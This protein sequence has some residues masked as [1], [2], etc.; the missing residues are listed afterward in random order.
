MT[1]R[2][3]DSSS[4]N[5]EVKSTKKSNS[6]NQSYIQTANL[7]SKTKLFDR[8]LSLNPNGI[9]PN[10]KV[11]NPSERSESEDVSPKSKKKSKSKNKQKDNTVISDNE[12][13]STI[14]LLLNETKEKV[15][16]NKSK[17]SSKHKN[18]D[19]Q[20]DA[21]SMKVLANIKSEIE[22]EYSVDSN[23]AQYVDTNEECLNGNDGVT[24]INQEQ[25]DENIVSSVEKKIH[26]LQDIRLI[27]VKDLTTQEQLNE[28]YPK[29]RKIDLHTKMKVKDSVD[30]YLL[31]VP[32]S[33]NPENLLNSE[34]NLEESC[35]VNIDGDSYT[36]K[37]TSNVP[38]PTLVLN[39]KTEILHFKKN[40]VLEKYIKAN[41]EPKIPSKEKFIVPLPSHLKNRHPLFGSNYEDRIQLDETIEE[42]LDEALKNLLKPSKSKKH[43]KVE[44]ANNAMGHST[45]LP[46]VSLTNDFSFDLSSISST[47]KTKKIKQ[48]NDDYSFIADLFKTEDQKQKKQKISK[49]K[50]DIAHSEEV[51]DEIKVFKRK[52]EPL[53]SSPK[54]KKKKK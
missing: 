15:L 14:A 46:D 54:K 35:R 28:L 20:N 43:K 6:I 49:N 23:E 42:K 21:V 51:N 13:E 34:I 4:D 5:G 45:L 26:L 37:P 7:M 53:D 1:K 3:N 12:R 32:K 47:K 40:L 44:K 17:K 38:D 2:K 36:I 41:K 16:K 31:H 27:P 33:V 39:N 24:Y 22:E 11:E 10:I 52:L 19:L 29:L 25:E 9:L 50:K 30:V 48:E 8:G 18:Q